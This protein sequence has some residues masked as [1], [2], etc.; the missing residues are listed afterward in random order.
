M[1]K[2]FNKAIKNRFGQKNGLHWTRLR[3]LLS[4][5][6]GMQMSMKGKVRLFVSIYLIGA[7]VGFFAIEI[8]FKGFG[9]PFGVLWFV[10][11]SFIQHRVLACPNCG[12]FVCKHKIW[13]VTYYAP[14]ANDKCSKCGVSF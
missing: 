1:S 5:A 11:F 3:A 7:I 14:F 6:L 10:F 12:E 13:R 9:I 8:L 4:F 2:T